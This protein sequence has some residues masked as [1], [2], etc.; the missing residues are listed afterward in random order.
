MKNTKLRESFRELI[1]RKVDSFFQGGG[2]ARCIMA[3]TLL[4]IIP[5]PLSY[6]FAPLGF[7]FIPAE[8]NSGIRKSRIIF[9]AIWAFVFFNPFTWIILYGIESEKNY[10]PKIE[11]GEFPCKLEYEV[12]GER[13]VCSDTLICEYKGYGWYMGFENTD[14]N[15]MILDGTSDLG[16]YEDKKIISL[17]FDIGYP[18]YH[19]GLSSGGK[20]QD[21]DEVNFIVFSENTYRVTSHMPAEAA[22]EKFGFRFISWECAPPIENNKY[23]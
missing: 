19:M 18:E 17:Y 11:Y 21:F 5:E 12:D 2:A 15:I 16:E 13:Y 3:V 1:V 14:D 22:Y 6:A 23:K 10:E 8:K 9:L 7:V 4:I 20:P